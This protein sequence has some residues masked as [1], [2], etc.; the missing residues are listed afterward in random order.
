MNNANYST[1]EL[2]GMRGLALANLAAAL[3]E[4]LAI[5]THWGAAFAVKADLRAVLGETNRRRRGLPRA[6]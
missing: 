4:E 2:E 1:A 3:R 6:A 5:T